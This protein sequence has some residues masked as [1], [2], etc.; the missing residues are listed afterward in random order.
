MQWD[1]QPNID[2]H[3]PPFF[4]WLCTRSICFDVKSVLHYSRCW[5]KSENIR[6]SRSHLCQR[7]P[8]FR[9]LGR[10]SA[11]ATRTKKV[12]TNDRKLLKFDMKPVHFLRMPIE[13]NISVLANLEPSSRITMGKLQ[14]CTIRNF[15]PLPPAF[16]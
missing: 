5:P 11:L 15:W 6:R 1:F 9:K 14:N 13:K 7:P 2:C 16:K 12:D 3:H 10:R 8:D 4:R